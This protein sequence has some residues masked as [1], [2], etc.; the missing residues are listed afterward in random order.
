MKE[1]RFVGCKSALGKYSSFYPEFII[2]WLDW[3]QE[4][5]HF[6]LNDNKHF[7]NVICV[8]PQHERMPIF[9]T[10]ARVTFRLDKHIHFSSSLCVEDVDPKLV[11]AAG[12]K[13]AL[14]CV[15]YTIQTSELESNEAPC[16]RS[17]MRSSYKHLSP[18]TVCFLRVHGLGVWIQSR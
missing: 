17:R 11:A 1:T 10:C 18:K 7:P 5:R 2:R 12:V 8:S 6:Q 14:L 13:L 4:G 15:Y 3:R 16:T 9:N